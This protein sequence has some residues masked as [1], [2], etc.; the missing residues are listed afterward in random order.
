MHFIGR[1]IC[2]I[3]LKIFCGIK[4][5]G[6]ENI[7]E[8]GGFI[9]ASNHLSFLDPPAVGVASPRPLNYMARHD[10]FNIPL[11]GRALLSVGAFPVKRGSADL[12]ALRSTIRLLESGEGVLLFPE[13]ARQEKGSV[14]PPE[15]GIGFIAAKSKVPVIPVFVSGTDT[16]LPRGAKFIRRSRVCVR[17]GK[18][19]PIERNM[20]YQEIA[21]RIMAHI[22]HL[23]C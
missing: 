12:A 9:L 4:A 16:A 2:A 17:F 15:P 22:R 18:Q 6:R 1:S 3:V 23:S 20:P 8:K 11:A 14:K 21:E 5:Y 13:G 10:L 19:I 7:P